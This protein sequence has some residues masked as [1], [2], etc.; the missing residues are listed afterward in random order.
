MI[1]RLIEARHQ[2]RKFSNISLENRREFGPNFATR[3]LPKFRT[4]VT[5]QAVTRHLEVLSDAGLVRSKRHGRE[6]LWEL[7][8]KRIE[9]AQRSL[10]QISRWWDEKLDVLKASVEE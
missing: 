3:L 9:L 6:R 5:R 10:N 2:P 7:E 1:R 4:D 8:P